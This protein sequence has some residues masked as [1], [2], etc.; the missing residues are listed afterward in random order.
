MALTRRFGGT[1]VTGRI[2]FG[3]SK[4]ARV[5]RFRAAKRSRIRLVLH[6][7]AAPLHCGKHA[8]DDLVKSFQGEARR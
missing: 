6:E 7:R 5:R 3:D 8:F 4:P 2:R 1:V